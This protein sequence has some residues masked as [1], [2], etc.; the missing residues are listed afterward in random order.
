MEL[1]GLRWSLGFLRFWRRRRFSR[2]SC[3]NCGPSSLLDLVESPSV[4]WCIGIAWVQEG[5]LGVALFLFADAVCV[6][7]ISTLIVSEIAAANGLTFENNSISRYI[8]RCL[9]DNS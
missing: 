3:R 4:E 9:L 1:W 8:S 6:G 2:S 7:R 5:E